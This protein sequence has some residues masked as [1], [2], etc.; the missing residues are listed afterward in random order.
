[1]PGNINGRSMVTNRTEITHQCPGVDGSR[2]GNQNLHKGERSDINP[3]K[4][5]QY[6]CTPLSRQIGGG[7]KEPDI[8][9]D[10]KEDMGFFIMQRVHA[11]SRICH[12][13][14]EC[15]SRLGVQEHLGLQRMETTSQNFPANMRKIGE[16][17][18]RSVCFKNISPT[19]KIHEQE[20][21]PWQ[22][23]HKCIAEGLG[24]HVPICVHTIQLDG[25]NPKESEET[26]YRH[27]SSD[28]SMGG[29]HNPG[30]PQLLGMTFCN[31]VMLHQT[32][33]LLSNPQGGT[34]HLLK[35]NTLKMAAWLI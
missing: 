12:I 4:S 17:T 16:A 22:R 13:R 32:K 20:I 10:N 6:H 19:P 23:S 30:T 26:Q 34:N 21:R 5:G 18:D 8:N 29:G 9:R 11:Y 33:T 27:D 25:P 35:N 1:M 3:L 7:D 15:N 2:A 14:T 28:T 24:T 31:P